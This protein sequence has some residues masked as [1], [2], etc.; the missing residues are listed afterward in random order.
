MKVQFLNAK[1]STYLK[2]MLVNAIVK[3]AIADLKLEDSTYSLT[4]LFQKDLHTDLD[5]YGMV[6]HIK[7]DIVM[8]LEPSA[9]IEDLMETL[10]H[11]MVH[12]KQIAKGQMRLV[13][14]SEAVIWLGKEHTGEIY[15]DLPWEIEAMAKS[16]RM[17]RKFTDLLFISSGTFDIAEDLIVEAEEE[18]MATRK[19][20]RIV[21]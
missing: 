7:K 14:D 8:A 11:E 15:Y 3:L 18:Q 13:K 1:K 16:E 19:D 12:V 9:E 10:C 17:Y 5:C 6:S 21:K 4:I 2:I 20:L